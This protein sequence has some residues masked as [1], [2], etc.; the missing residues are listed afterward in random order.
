MVCTHN[1]KPKI[2]AGMLGWSQF[3]G[4]RGR[5]LLSPSRRSVPAMLWENAN[6]VSQV[7]SRSTAQLQKVLLSRLLLSWP[8]RNHN[9]STSR[10]SILGM[11]RAADMYG[12]EVYILAQRSGGVLIVRSPAGVGL[13]TPCKLNVAALESQR[14]SVRTGRGPAGLNLRSQCVL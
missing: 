1:C 13:T 6:T 10:P 5:L 2:A 14:F 7:C 8:G 12:H 3:P 11:E 4:C 9:S